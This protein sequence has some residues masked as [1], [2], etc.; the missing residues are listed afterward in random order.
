[1]NKNEGALLTLCT[2]LAIIIGFALGWSLP[3]K[4]YPCEPLDIGYEAE[5]YDKFTGHLVDIVNVEHG[6]EANYL[7]VLSKRLKVNKNRLRMQAS[8]T[9]GE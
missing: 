1:M 2:L 8:A 4:P 6:E 3:V 7:L 5:I 9:E